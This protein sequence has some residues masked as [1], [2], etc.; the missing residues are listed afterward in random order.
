MATIVPRKKTDGSTVYTAQIRL[1]IDGRAYSESK[2]FFK[3]TMAVAWANERADEI[4]RNPALAARTEGA[5]VSIR[6]LIERYLADRAGVE[7]LGRSKASHL[8]MLASMAI[9]EVPALALTRQQLVAHVQARRLAG[10]GPST[11]ANDLIW[12]RVVFR[13]ARTA[14]GLP[15]DRLVIDD[16]AELCRA[17]RLTGSSL[18]RSRRPS[19]A[20]LVQL[21]DWFCAPRLYGRASEQTSGAPMYLIMWFAIYSCRRMSEIF[22]LRLADFDR[23]HRTWLVRDVKNPGGSG[24]NHLE[25]RV[26][27]R[28]LEVIDAI[29]AQVPRKDD[30]LLP[31]NA[32]T[33]GTY[34]SNHLKLCG[35]EDLHFHDLRHEGCSRLAEDGLSIPQIQQVSLHESWGSLQVYVNTR[36]R[37]TAR[38]E[39]EP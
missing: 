16:A 32:K 28:L 19:D 10:A 29:I 26:T 30:R 37:K 35:I 33:I 14:L 2:T 8:K 34:W 22:S 7:P 1:R 18:K 23:E 4:K 39:F 13:Y 25:M 5:G 38:V 27:D 9:A 31:F 20:E 3:R 6:D 11:A 12:L 17:E 21:R 15:L 24:G 36:L